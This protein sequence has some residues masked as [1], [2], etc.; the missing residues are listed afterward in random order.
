[1]TAMAHLK[2]LPLLLWVGFTVCTEVDLH[3]RIFHDHSC[4]KNDSLY[5]VQIIQTNRTHYSHLCGGSLIHREWVL[6]AAHCWINETGWNMSAYVGIHP[7]PGREVT[8]TDHKIFENQTEKHDIMLLKINPPEN[9]IKPVD[10]PQCP[11][12][13]QMDVIQIAG[14]GGYRVNATYHKLPGK[15]PHLQCAKMHVVKCGLNLT[16]CNSTLLWPNGNTMC[17]KEPRVDTCPGDSGGGVIYNNTIYGVHVGGK[18][19]ACKGPATSLKVC[20]YIHWIMPFI[21]PNNGK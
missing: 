9:K 20:S 4:E 12:P 7:G 3:K 14:L 15:P 16:P 18:Q 11:H 13:K 17:Y 5:Y 10:L 8:I 6:T 19:C 2:F 21:T 1:M